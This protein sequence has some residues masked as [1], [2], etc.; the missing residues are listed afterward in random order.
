MFDNA[1]GIE[2]K[3]IEATTVLASPYFV[4]GTPSI[5]ELE[6]KMLLW[7]KTSTCGAIIH[8]RP[9]IG[10]TKAIT[11][12][13]ESIHENFD[14]N[15]PVFIWNI[16]DHDWNEKGF[17]SDLSMALKMQNIRRTMTGTEIKH[18]VI[19]HLTALAEQGK[20]RKIVILIDEAYNLGKREFSWLMD[21]YNNLS[22]NNIRLTTFLVGSEELMD[23]KYELAETGCSQILGRFMTRESV[24]RGIE[25]EDE[26]KTC[27]AAF[28][29]K[30][31]NPKDLNC[32]YNLE[33]LFFPHAREHG[34]GYFQML[35]HAFWSEFQ[36]ARGKAGI[37]DQDIPMQYFM[38]SFI[39]LLT[40][41]GEGGAEPHVWPDSKDIA[42]AI[43][44]SDY[45][46]SKIIVPPTRKKN[47]GKERNGR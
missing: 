14:A 41:F 26:M 3:R 4:I 11:Y 10:K 18:A 43:E 30:I 35:S 16:T 7:L 29:D 46:Y 39:N 19:S 8:G 6:E 20:Y 44:L 24:F 21:I 40:L 12:M 32:E 1:E 9:R 36:S 47:G 25:T 22:V 5:Y 15:M 34:K 45:K 37:D 27:L 33:E 28:D 38:D 2:E 42:K 13:L 17:Y 23:L 31:V